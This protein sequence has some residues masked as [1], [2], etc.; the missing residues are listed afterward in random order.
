MPVA[1]VHAGHG[2]SFGRDRLKLIVD[3]YLAGG[4][5]IGD[6]EEWLAKAMG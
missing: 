3:E 1:I 4:R 6:L 2:L 5:R